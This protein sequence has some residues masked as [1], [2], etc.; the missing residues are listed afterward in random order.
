MIRLLTR[1]SGLHDNHSL[2]STINPIRTSIDWE[3]NTRLCQGLVTSTIDAIVTYMRVRPF[4]RVMGIYSTL[5][6]LQCLYYIVHLAECWSSPNG[7]LL[8]DKS[9]ETAVLCLQ[10]MAA[11][12]LPI[13]QHSLNVLGGMICPRGPAPP[14]SSS[15][16]SDDSPTRRTD[17]PGSANGFMPNCPQFSL[18]DNILESQ[19]TNPA[20]I[21]LYRSL[22]LTG[23]DVQ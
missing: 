1:S 19:V 14:P 17:T 4:Q 16:N 2:S 15:L 11:T 3:H 5:V 22:G 7:L 10:N 13:A 8:K 21:D 9:V 23:L 18:H 6:L 12:G 20:I